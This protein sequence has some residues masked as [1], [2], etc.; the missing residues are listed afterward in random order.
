MT[1]GSC[2]GAVTHVVSARSAIEA[3]A[4]GFEVAIQSSEKFQDRFVIIEM[5][6]QVIVKAVQERSYPRIYWRA[7]AQKKKR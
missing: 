3:E 6:A 5:D 4:R 1:E 7:S 2:L